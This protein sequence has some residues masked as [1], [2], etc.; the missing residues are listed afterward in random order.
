MKAKMQS[1]QGKK[2]YKKRGETVEWPFGDIKQNLGL[3][4]FL[5]RGLLN[6]KTEHNLVCTAHNM[7]VLWKKLDGKIA[8]LGKMK[9]AGV[10]LSSATDNVLE[11][12]SKFIQKIPRGINC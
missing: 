3:R 11:V 12:C 10:I 6:V 5:T 7:K 8:V 1:E 2:E 9:H 4:E